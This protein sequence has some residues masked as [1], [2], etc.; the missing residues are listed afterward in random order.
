MLNQDFSLVKQILSKHKVGYK[1]TMMETI[2][3][4]NIQCYKGIE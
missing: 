1:T 3:C 2:Q 4:K